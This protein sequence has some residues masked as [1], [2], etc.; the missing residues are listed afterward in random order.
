MCD[1]DGMSGA[2]QYSRTCKDAMNEADLTAI[3]TKVLNVV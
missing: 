1:E 2:R 3:A